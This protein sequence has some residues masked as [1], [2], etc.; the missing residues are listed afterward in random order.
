MIQD[1]SPE[2]AAIDVCHTEAECQQMYAAIPPEVKAPAL[3]LLADKLQNV[4]AE[5]VGAYQAD[6]KHWMAPHHFLWGMAV[7]NLLR[8]EGYGE[9]Y[10]G[11]HNLDDIYVALIEEALK[12]GILE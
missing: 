10:F 3:T 2:A 6:P 5:V 4:R 12:L 7:R 1:R 8:K 11:V 9:A